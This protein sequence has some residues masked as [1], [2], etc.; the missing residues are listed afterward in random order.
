MLASLLCFSVTISGA[1][2]KENWLLLTSF[3]VHELATSL[4]RTGFISMVSAHQSMMSGVFLGVASG[5][6]YFS[7]HPQPLI[8]TPLAKKPFVWWQDLIRIQ[9]DSHKMSSQ[10]FSL[11]VNEMSRLHPL[12]NSAIGTLTCWARS[13][14]WGENTSLGLIKEK[15]RKTTS[16]VWSR[17]FICL[18]SW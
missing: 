6:I 15:I 14:C 3:V 2:F 5:G 1:E 18:I 12:I 10:Y 16:T 7:W 11:E 9:S 17:S 8:L 4:L 13:N